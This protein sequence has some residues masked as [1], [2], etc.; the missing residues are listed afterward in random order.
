M[1]THQHKC[2]RCGYVWRH[3]DTWAGDPEAHT[4][5]YCGSRVWK[6]YLGWEEGE[7]HYTAPCTADDYYDDPRV[8]A[9]DILTLLDYFTGFRGR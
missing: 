8:P 6:R 3:P 5:R 9:Y 4:C 1:A 7:R 2:E